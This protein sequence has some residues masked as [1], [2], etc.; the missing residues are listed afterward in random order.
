M[1]QRLEEIPVAL[2][3]L[4]PRHHQRDASLVRDTERLASLVSTGAR[5]TTNHRIGN[6]AMAGW[7]ETQHVPQGVTGGARPRDEYADRS[8]NHSIERIVEHTS[9][10]PVWIR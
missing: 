3:R 4:E 9:R 5:V 1:C 6:H 10:R 7:F 2:A 8:G